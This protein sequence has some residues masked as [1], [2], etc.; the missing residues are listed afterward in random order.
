M[1]TQ[2]QNIIKKFKIK[3]YLEDSTIE[4][5][6]LKIKNSGLWPGKILKR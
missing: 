2:I 3:F 6:E 5:F 1:D 4:I